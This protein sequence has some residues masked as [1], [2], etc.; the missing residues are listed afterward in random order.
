MRF[1]V[2]NQFGRV[3]YFSFIKGVRQRCINNMFKYIVRLWY[4]TLI[5]YLNHRRCRRSKVT[6]TEIGAFSPGKSNTQASALQGILYDR[7]RDGHRTV[8]RTPNNIGTIQLL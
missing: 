5:C 4:N 7:S 3:L 8:V 1:N 2:L 6:D